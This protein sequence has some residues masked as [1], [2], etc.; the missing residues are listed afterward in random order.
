M[1]T[2]RRWK[3]VQW[4]EE[5]EGKVRLTARHFGYS[6]D[7]ISRW[8]LAYRAD[9]VRGLEPN[10]RRPRSLR[11]P[12]ASVE[13]VER[14]RAVRERYPSWGREK[15]R[16]LLSEEGITLSAKSIDRVI[17]RCSRRVGYSERQYSPT[18]LSG[19]AIRGCDAPGS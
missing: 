12:Q 15:L 13:V 18:R 6:P 16:V 8:V 17:G 3:V 4:C 10:S 9:G 5:H 7:T 19:D 14:V 1:E 2:K 11:R